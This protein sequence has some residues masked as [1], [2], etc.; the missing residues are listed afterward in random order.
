MI[1]INEEGFFAGIEDYFLKLYMYKT[2]A[3][4]KIIA[5]KLQPI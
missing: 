2:R 4:P 5:D 3:I 1:S